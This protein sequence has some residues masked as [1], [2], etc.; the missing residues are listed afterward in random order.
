MSY[1]KLKSE[2][3]SNFGGLNIKSSQYITD[4]TQFLRIENLDFSKLGAHQKD[5]GSTQFSTGITQKITGIGELSVVNQ[6]ITQSG[7]TSATFYFNPLGTTIIGDVTYAV[8]SS[9][10][11]G[12]TNYN[13]FTGD[14]NVFYLSS[15]GATNIYDY[16]GN[17][18]YATLGL[19]PQFEPDTQFDFLP[20][21]RL[22]FCNGVEFLQMGVINTGSTSPIYGVTIMQY[23]LPA[24]VW[25]GPMVVTTGA[26]RAFQLDL[27]QEFDFIFRFIR[28]DGFQGPLGATSINPYN[29][30]LGSPTNRASFAA[31]LVPGIPGVIPFSDDQQIWG[32]SGMMVWL[33]VN[34]ATYLNYR[35]PDTG[36]YI[37][38]FTS[39]IGVDCSFST[40]RGTYALDP[41]PEN[42]FN[43][44]FLYPFPGESVPS[45]GA[46]PQP[47]CIEAFNNQLFMAGLSEDNYY[48][49]AS[50]VVYSNIGQYEQID[51]ENFFSVRP[52][53]GDVVT[54]LR[55]YFTELVI[56]KRYS[57]HSLRGDN[58]DNFNL[59]IATLEYGCLGNNAACV[60][61]QKL[62]FLDQKGICEYNGA[63]TKIISNPVQ[64]IFERMNISNA[65]KFASIIHV[66]EKNEVWCF[67]PTDGNTY[68][69]TVVIYDY[70]A[71]AWRTRT[72]IRNTTTAAV[73][74]GTYGQ[75]KP[76][77]GTYSGMAF[78][79]DQDYL[80]DNGVGFTCISQS[81]FIATE[82]G[83]SV[84]KQFR[85]FYLDADVEGASVPILI[86]FY[87]NQGTLP[88]YSQTMILNNF[89]NRIDFGIP[90]KDLSVEMVY[91]GDT[92]LRI[93]GFTIEYRFQ[94]AT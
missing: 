24:P 89:Q 17:R 39:R 77:I 6:T 34:G 59:S 45:V 79:F 74:Q 30:L 91:G 25:G 22:F 21:Q 20:L 52:D 26:S 93:N 4:Q 8:S 85:R 35:N 54:A 62:W 51:P 75:P 92:P 71:N 10:I 36:D 82:L 13:I 80:T 23:S 57:T 55:T 69:D 40:W 87:S 94:R 3:Y 64:P 72:N 84:E 60:W 48:Y 56:F 31:S 49:N 41:F 32:I 67:I 58:P 18:F 14:K 78:A 61:E 83:H 47:S 70:L 19:P 68:C 7:F 11:Y 5:W 50:D 29:F 1:A 44:S 28:S 27:N 73:I 46:F 86:N 12:I 9:Y 37:L 90:A 81:R 65:I 2:N 53:D 33:S 88:V 43:G 15:G 38:G 66:K 76:M 63:N 16:L 42:N